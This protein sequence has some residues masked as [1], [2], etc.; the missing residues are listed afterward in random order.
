MRDIREM[1]NAYEPDKKVPLK[2]DELLR[3]LRELPKPSK[4]IYVEARVKG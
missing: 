4:H 2:T 1:A 3:A